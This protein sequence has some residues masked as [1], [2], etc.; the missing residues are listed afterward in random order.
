MAATSIA[1]NTITRSPGI[2]SAVA[3]ACDVPNGN[4]LNGNTGGCWI[5]LTNT[6]AA[7]RTVNFTIPGASDSVAHPA[8]PTTIPAG[9]TWRFGPWPTTVYGTSLTFQAD[10]ALVKY[11]AYQLSAS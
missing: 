1:L 3:L 7:P 2:A 9:A 11:A 10:S 4:V 5:E 8:K 6:D